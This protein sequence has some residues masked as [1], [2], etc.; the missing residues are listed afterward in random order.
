T[1]LYEKK[2]LNEVQH[3]MVPILRKWVHEN[4]YSISEE[5]EKNYKDLGEF[6]GQNCVMKLVLPQL[7]E[8]GFEDKLDSDP[9]AVPEG[10]WVRNLKTGKKHLR[11]KD[12]Y[13]TFAF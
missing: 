1:N 9:F 13:W 6:T 5:N 11:T 10:K 8:E 12:D 4:Q 7:Y 3:W 2:A